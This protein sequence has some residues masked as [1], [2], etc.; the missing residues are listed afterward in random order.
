MPKILFHKLK[1]NLTAPAVIDVES[2][3]ILMDCIERY[4]PMGF[5]SQVEMFREVVND[6]HLFFTDENPTDLEIPINEDIHIVCR[7]QGFDPITLLY[8]AVAAVAAAVVI[9][10]TVAVNPNDIGNT[11]QSPNNQV[12]GQTN[13]ARLGQ[14]IPYLVGRNRAYPDLIG[15][16]VLEYVDNDRVII[17]Q[18]CVG[19]NHHELTRSRQGESFI[20]DIE[21]TTVEYFQPFEFPDEQPLESFSADNITGQELVGPNESEGFGDEATTDGFTDV[22]IINEVAVFTVN[23]NPDVVTFASNTLPFPVEIEYTRSQVVI[24]GQGGV[25]VIDVL[26]VGTGLL[27]SA[28]F[29]DNS[30]LP[31]PTEDQY[32]FRIEGFNGPAAEGTDD[33]PARYGDSVDLR[34]KLEQFIGPF[35][36]NAESDQ[37]WIDFVFQRGLFGD[38]D[39]LIST[40]QVDEDG[41]VIPGTFESFTQTYNDSTFDPQFRTLKLTPAAGF[42]RYSFGVT[43]TNNASTSSQSPD[44]CKIERLQSVRNTTVTNYGNVTWARLTTSAVPESVQSERQFN[45]IATR[46]TQSYRSG[47][48]DQTLRASRAGS[49][50]ILQIFIDSNRRPLEELDLDELYSIYNGLT[51]PQL[52]Y[53][54]FT[55][56][57]EDISLRQRI[58]VVA[59]AARVVAYR[60]GLVW[61]FVRDDLKPFKT[62]SF[63]RRN[64]YSGRSH[65]QTWRGHLPKSFDSIELTWRDVDTTNKDQFVNL[66][67]NTETMSIDV[68]DDLSAMRPKRL[69]ISGITNETQAVNRAQL[70][71]RKLLYERLSV[72]DTILNDGY[73]VGPG[74]IGYWADVYETS[75]NDGE[76][77]GISGNVIDTSE[78]IR[79]EGGQVYYVTIT[80]DL[81]EP[82]GRVQ[83]TQ[84][85]DTEFGFNATL[86]GVILANL[87]SVQAGSRYILS[88]TTELDRS[89]FRLLSRSPKEGENG[90]LLVD[91]EMIQYDVRTY[92]FDE[93]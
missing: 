84:R 66:A 88:T 75:I 43:R 38:V 33:D 18:F 65:T 25:G 3:E 73:N 10:T 69:T 56:D 92:E 85:S 27:T 23:S 12:N 50:S 64:I 32:I 4:F 81:G 58:E 74:D 44:Q 42:G 22:E 57:D 29:V 30:G 19:L 63:N 7:P 34:Q 9:A 87:T 71:V 15:E 13:I 70:E 17:E 91:V 6:D 86:D 31:D 36:T 76:I 79:F 28:T 61:A 93:V 37:L 48:I 49:D 82:Q 78:R 35:L 60:N 5:G 83:A 77:V 2:G 11:K 41:V 14:A 46:M 40:N 20:D 67:I 21:G 54:D 16:P 24:T 68:V 90:Q 55:F 8:V 72:K 39:L 1:A 51:D 53:C 59:N 45:V 52:G 47:M 62:F 89:T 80:N 26:E